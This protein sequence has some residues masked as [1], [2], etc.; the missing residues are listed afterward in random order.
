VNAKGLLMVH[1]PRPEQENKDSVEEAD[2][3]DLAVQ[4]ARGEPIRFVLAAADGK[5]MVPGTIVP[6]PIEGK[7]GNCRLEIRLATPDA[8]A[9]L[10]YA[11]GLP[12]NTDV[13]F[14]SNSAG[15]SEQAKFSANGNGHAA[16]A[17][18]PYVDGKG[19]GILKT[20]LN[21]KQCSVSVGI[22]WG[23]GTYKPL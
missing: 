16:T 4:A 13:P 17:D 15:E 5:F 1:K 9:V 14:Q 6:F 10:I 12:P 8:E 20:V 11:D 21:T 7:D 18:L 3:L 23:K 2:E 22:P 19:S